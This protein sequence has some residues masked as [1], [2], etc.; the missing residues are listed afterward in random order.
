MRCL[1]YSTTILIIIWCGIPMMAV[2]A[3]EGLRSPKNTY[4]ESRSRRIPFESVG[5]ELPRRDDDDDD[6]KQLRRLNKKKQ[7]QKL[8]KTTTTITASSNS[9]D[10]SSAVVGDAASYHHYFKPSDD[11]NEGEEIEEAS[12]IIQSHM[13]MPLED[14]DQSVSII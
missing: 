5:Y 12:A 4:N 11:F 9:N 2:N 6:D 14:Q 3:A 10:G 8:K 1:L 7:M 13:S